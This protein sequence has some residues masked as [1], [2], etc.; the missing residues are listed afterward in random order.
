MDDY[1]E[2]DLRKIIENILAKWYWV[3]I[4]AS[5]IGIAVFLYSYFLMPDIYRANASV[6]IT[7]PNNM[8]NFFDDLETNETTIP[9]SSAVSS[10]ARSDE[11]LGDLFEIWETEDKGDKTIRNLREILTIEASDNDML[12]TL[13]VEAQSPREAAS[14]ANTW[15]TLVIEKVNS[16]F[17][18]Y[19][20][21]VID[22]LG[23][24]LAAARLKLDQG[25]DALNEFIEKDR[26]PLLMDR[27]SSLKAE[28][29]QTFWKQRQLRDARFDSLGVLA[30][31]ETEPDNERVSDSFRIS[32]LLIQ[33]RLY[34]SGSDIMLESPTD[35][36][37]VSSLEL[38][39][40]YDMEFMTVSEFRTRLENWVAVID[41]Q[42]EELEA[43]EEAYINEI[44]RLESEIRSLDI[45]YQ[46]LEDNLLTFTNNNQVVFRKYEALS[47]M[48]DDG[49]PGYV[50]LASSA[51][52]P[53]ERLAHNTLRNSLI[54]GVAGGFL[55]LAGVVIA[56]WWKSGVE[57]TDQEE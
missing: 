24:Q 14:L 1:L 57:Q 22:Q 5:V 55:G 8:P 51:S 7:N 43:Q 19:G 52:V 15:A 48:R 9:S 27:V 30:Q 20:D 17:F 18:N 45:E 21:D 53:E 49:G 44:N 37:S 38:Q 28:Q 25:K 54:G 35:S 11:L 56:D 23:S 2:I 26:R 47:L 6:L 31:L 33:S 34:S 29:S 3:V 36:I 46:T 10:L 40:Q 41:N 12:Y 16:D 32:Y 4:P 39:N 50:R 42:L 13:S